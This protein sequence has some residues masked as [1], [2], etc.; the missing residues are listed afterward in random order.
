MTDRMIT[1]LDAGDRALFHRFLLSGRRVRSRTIATYLTHLGGARVSVAACF[2]P[3]LAPGSWP[4][5]ARHALA[6]LIVSH[7]LV[8]VVKRSVGRP[9]P[10]R[11]TAAESWVAEPDRFSFPSGH[12]AAALAVALAYAV[13]WPALAV[14]FLA[15]AMAIGASR[16]ALGVHYPGDVAAGQA[17]AVI[18]HLLLARTHL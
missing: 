10:S 11:A 1:R 2:W 12:A 17:I 6:T 4:G 5:V 14:P 3:L 15:L 18:T 7:L 8:Q 16:V 9:R 13:V